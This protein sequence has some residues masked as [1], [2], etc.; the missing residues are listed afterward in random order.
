MDTDSTAQCHQMTCYGGNTLFI[1]GPF[2]VDINCL[3]LTPQLSAGPEQE[4]M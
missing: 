4:S 2:S 3:L 1:S